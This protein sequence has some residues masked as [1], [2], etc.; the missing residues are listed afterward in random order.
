GTIACTAIGLRK[1]DTSKIVRTALISSSFFLA[2]LVNIR[3]GPSS[4]HLS[5]LAP[6]GLILGWSSFPAM[7]IALFLQAVLFHFGGLLVLG[8]NTFIMG[9][10]A[11]IVHILFGKIIR[12]E[13]KIYSGVIA[14]IAGVSAVLM[15]ACLVG[16]FLGIS[17]MNFLEAA[18]LLFYAHIPLALIEGVVTS[19][20]I[21][22]LK[23]TSPEFLS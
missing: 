12:S 21:M 1:T 3:I 20:M 5:L 18:K 16:V 17:D 2:S 10:P 15:G 13:S 22:F 23:R 8:A 9:I 4:T 19:F 14:F 11:L 6:V 7:L